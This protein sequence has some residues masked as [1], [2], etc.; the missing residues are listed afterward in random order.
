VSGCGAQVIKSQSFALVSLFFLCHGTHG[1]FCPHRSS[2]FKRETAWGGGGAQADPPA[3]PLDARDGPSTPS[4]RRSERRHPPGR[5]LEPVGPSGRI[6]GGQH[7]RTDTGCLSGKGSRRPLPPDFGG[8]SPEELTPPWP[9]TT[10][11]TPAP[12]PRCKG[13][14]EKVGEPNRGTGHATRRTRPDETTSLNKSTETVSGGDRDRHGRSDIEASSPRRRK[15]Y[16]EGAGAPGPAPTGRIFSV[17][18]RRERDVPTP[19]GPR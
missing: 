11:P 7:S 9:F 13:R 16:Q 3:G 2:V 15:K 4:T 18:V 1:F 5:T 12:R 14:E 8:L 19:R 6:D 10:I 17:D